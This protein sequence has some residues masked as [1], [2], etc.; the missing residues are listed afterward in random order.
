MPAPAN[1]QG[2]RQMV[3]AL[4]RGEAIGML[5]DQVPS[6]GEGV[7]APFFGKPAYTMTLPAKLHQMTGATIVLVYSE[8][9]ARGRGWTVHFFRFDDDP[10]GTTE[11][12]TARINAAIEKVILERPEQYFWGY[13]RYKKPKGAPSA[14]RGEGLEKAREGER[15]EGGT[16]APDRRP[17]P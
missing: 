15:Q 3:R 17:D 10:S 1:M 2:V 5:P 4:K 9:L 6:V 14:E 11:E 12:R 7:W 13:D 8:R 16:A